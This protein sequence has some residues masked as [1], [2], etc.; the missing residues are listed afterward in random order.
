MKNGRSP[1]IAPIASSMGMQLT[2]TSMQENI[3]S[4]SCRIASVDAFLKRFPDVDMAFAIM[5][6]SV[7]A[8]SAGCPSEFKGSVPVITGHPFISPSDLELL[9]IPDPLKDKAMR[10]NI[11]L[12]RHLAATSGKDVA[13]FVIGP[14][15][16][17]AHLLGITPLVIAS[18]KHPPG[19]EKVLNHCTKF[20][21]PYAEDLA[22]AGASYIVV[23]EP[24]VIFFS[25]AVFESSI[26]PFLEELASGL[27]RPVLHV[28]GDTTRH[29]RA[30]AHLRY[31]DILSLDTKVDFPRGLA[32]VPELSHKTLM[33]NIDPV[34]VLLRGNPDLVSQT[35][36]SLMKSMA[37]KR[38]ILSSGCDVPPHTPPE[39][40]D[41]ALSTARMLRG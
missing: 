38:F 16:L 17:S 23:L 13:A 24:Q 18:R 15:T 35:V 4:L 14:V 7:E 30:F 36:S 25:P 20:I 8:R 1:L 28:C 37:G 11:D 12:V 2:R 34:N 3:A 10:P 22:G 32:D 6:T 29:L 39:N 21:R 27:P 9:K 41:A 5:D 40:L 19:F 26:S 31:F 33:G